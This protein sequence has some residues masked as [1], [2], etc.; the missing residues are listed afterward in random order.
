M[1]QPLNT[2]SAAKVLD[3]SPHWLYV[4]AERL[5]IPRYRIGGR[6]LYFESELTDWFIA[7]KEVY[8]P[9]SSH[10]PKSRI[11]SRMHVEFS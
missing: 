5:R 6:W 8:E 7:Q 1:N 10:V 11:P 4:N 3:K 2:A 9:S